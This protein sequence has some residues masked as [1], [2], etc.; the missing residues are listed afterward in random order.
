MGARIEATIPEQRAAQV[1]AL[2]E[3][4]GVTKSQLIDEALALFAKAVSETRRGRR[5]GFVGGD[6]R[7]VE[8]TSPVLN[9]VEWALEPEPITLSVGD[10]ARVGE[11]NAAPPQPAPALKKAVARRRPRG[12]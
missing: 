12:R 3:E 2:E 5:V 4:L 7:V 10:F 6:A 1:R 9:L 11:L 8:F